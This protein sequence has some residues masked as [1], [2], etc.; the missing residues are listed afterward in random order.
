VV[1][2]EGLV[3]FVAA[4]QPSPQFKIAI[5][6][7]VGSIRFFDQ[8]KRYGPNRVVP[9]EDV[10]SMPGV[11]TLDENV[12][13]GIIT[14]TSTFAPGVEE[15]FSRFMPHRIELKPKEILIPWLIGLARSGQA[16]Q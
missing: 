16:A 14:T 6:H 1:A 15:E 10:R 7:G 9:A 8:V 13:K 4:V 12:S 2:P 11:L 3:A 5:K